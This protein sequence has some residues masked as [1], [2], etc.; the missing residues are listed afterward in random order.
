MQLCPLL[1][2][3]ARFCHFSSFLLFSLAS[4]LKPQLSLQ[5]HSPYYILYRAEAIYRIL[6][7]GYF[8][9]GF[10][11]LRWSLAQ[12]QRSPSQLFTYTASAFQPQRSS[13]SQLFSFAQQPQLF[14]LS[15]KAFLS[16]STADKN[17][18]SS[19]SPTKARVPA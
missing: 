1:G 19:F 12:L 18:F 9:S 16:H 17:Q 2:A 3:P 6:V 13:P 15:L 14:S 11:K 4:G 8:Y 10:R 7:F 5:P